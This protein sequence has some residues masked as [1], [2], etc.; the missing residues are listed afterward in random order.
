MVVRRLLV[1]VLLALLVG[2]AESDPLQVVLD[3]LL[4]DCDMGA[5]F[6]VVGCLVQ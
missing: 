6:F 2:E 3:A 4:E 5:L 1:R